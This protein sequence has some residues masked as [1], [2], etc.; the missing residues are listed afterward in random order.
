[1][2]EHRILAVDDEPNMLLL[3]ERI[4]REKTPYAIETCNNSL[5]VPRILKERS[6]D[7][8]IS[9]LKMPGLDGIDILRLVKQENRDEEV[10]II[11]AFGS[12]D[13]AVAALSQ[14][15]YDYITKP[16]KKEQIIST[17][18]RAMR[19]QRARRE[20]ARMVEIFNGE[21]YADRHFMAAVFPFGASVLPPDFSSHLMATPCPTRFRSD[22]QRFFIFMAWIENLK[23]DFAAVSNQR[24]NNLCHCLDLI[25]WNKSV[26][27]HHRRAFVYACLQ[28]CADH[29]FHPRPF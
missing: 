12:L 22:W 23:T 17:L 29:Y 19:W 6:F 24:R 2:I 15:V 26:L 27:L 8:I 5:E 9:D 16:F 28:L 10:I 14:G 7:L 4:V 25:F 3:L 13:S 11:T 18:D 1:M 20:S 21:P